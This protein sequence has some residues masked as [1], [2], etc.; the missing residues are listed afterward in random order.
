MLCDVYTLD[1]QSNRKMLSLLLGKH[2]VTSDIAVDGQEAVEMVLSDPE[3]YSLVLMDNMMP[4][5]VREEHV[6]VHQSTAWV[7]DMSTSKNYAA[8]S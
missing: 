4:R 1:V 6:S 7:S 2:Q 8:K 5:K 3:K